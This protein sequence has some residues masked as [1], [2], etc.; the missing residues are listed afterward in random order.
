MKKSLHG[1]T[2]YQ[3]VILGYT[4]VEIFLPPGLLVD[5]GGAVGTSSLIGG[6]EKMMQDD[7]AMG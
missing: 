3:L 5:I 6:E 7:W 4:L 1:S 2:K